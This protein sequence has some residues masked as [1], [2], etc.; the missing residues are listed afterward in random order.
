MPCN[1]HV[2]HFLNYIYILTGLKEYLRRYP[3]FVSIEDILWHKVAIKKE[4]TFFPDILQHI[5]TLPDH[6]SLNR[7]RKYA[8]RYPQHP[9]ANCKE[10]NRE[11]KFRKSHYQ[12][13]F[14]FLVF[15]IFR[16]DNFLAFHG[17]FIFHGMLM[18]HFFLW[19]IPCQP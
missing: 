5:I 14:V 1:I 17:F 7:F 15:H 11:H 9:D 2:P 16:I 4:K 13:I 10:E 8:I 3:G 18:A 12:Y 6:K 19:N